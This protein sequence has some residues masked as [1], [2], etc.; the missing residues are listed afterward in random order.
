MCRTCGPRF[1]S[2]STLLNPRQSLASHW[3]KFQSQ[4]KAWHLKLDY[5]LHRYTY[6]SVSICICK[7]TCMCIYMCIHISLVPFSQVKRYVCLYN[8]TAD[9]LKE[10]L[11]LFSNKIF[12]S[13]CLLISCQSHVVFLLCFCVFTK[14][15]RIT[16]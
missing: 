12:T 1:I 9:L 16:S 10:M 14:G 2:P 6:P 3:S 7:Y 15:R 11:P 13:S 5:R 8:H 4:A